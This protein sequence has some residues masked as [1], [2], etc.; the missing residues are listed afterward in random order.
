M[1]DIIVGI[2]VA[3]KKVDVAFLMNSKFT[4]KEYPN[5]EKGYLCIVTWIKSKGFDTA[6]ICMEA[7]G[8]YS[9]KVAEYFHG[10][11][12]PVSVVN[13]FQIKRYGQSRL[14]RN[15]TDRADA[16]VIAQFAEAMK[17]A[18]W[19]PPSPTLKGLKTNIRQVDRL[20]QMLSQESN[21]AL[22]ERDPYVLKSI[23][24][25]IDCL[26]KEIKQFENNIDNDIKKDPELKEQRK[27]LESIPG[28]GPETAK[29]LIANVDI[30]RFKNA[31][32]ISAFIGVNP[33][34]HQS[35]SSVRGRTRISK[36]GDSKLRKAFY[37]PAVVSIRYNPVVK[38]FYEN[39]V[40]RGKPKMVALCAAMRK[41]LHIAYGVLKA[42]KP[43]SIRISRQG[44]FR[45]K[46]A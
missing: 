12:F 18:L 7:T 32:Q 38:E 33:R 22:E 46:N 14:L 13:P 16:R 45:E 44:R 10:I 41:L 43:F 19:Q 37:M 35:G 25:V 5:N 1:Q 23:E 6:F 36:M 20:K 27:L 29:Q 17:P 15:K 9:E 11:G 31:K 2:D 28:I 40:N 26:K 39:L 4:M 24:R 42:K 3:K 21:R 8:T 30:N 34:Q